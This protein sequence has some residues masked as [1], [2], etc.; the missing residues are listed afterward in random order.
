MKRN[1]SVKEARKEAVTRFKEDRVFE[2]SVVRR[3][4][5]DGLYSAFLECEF[6]KLFNLGK[7]WNLNETGPENIAAAMM[8]SLV[9]G[10]DTTPN[11]CFGDYH[12]LPIMNYHGFSVGVKAYG[13]YETCMVIRQ[14]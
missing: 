6:G 3:M 9:T 5:K 10:I 13:R 12:Q 11:D 7:D 14:V 8:I 4:P 2:F 1:M